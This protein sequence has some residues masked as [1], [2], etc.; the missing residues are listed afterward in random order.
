MFIRDI[1]KKCEIRKEFL[2]VHPMKDTTTGEDFFLAL[3]EYL[4]KVNLTW[5]KIVSVTTDGCPS[6]TGKNVGLLKQIRDK[7]KE[8]QP[9]PD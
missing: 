6:L 1:N 7:V 4:V 3:E 9:E 2:S 5:N 8:L